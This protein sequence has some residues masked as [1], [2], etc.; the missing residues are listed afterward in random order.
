[1]EKPPNFAQTI[2]KCK[3]ATTPGT[4]SKTHIPQIEQARSR[5]TT[6]SIF[7]CT[8][9]CKDLQ[10]NVQELMQLSEAVL[11]LTYYQ[12]LVILIAYLWCLWRT[13]HGALLDEVWLSWIVEALKHSQSQIVRLLAIAYFYKKHVWAAVSLQERKNYKEFSILFQSRWTIWASTNGIAAPTGPMW[14][15]LRKIIAD[16][17]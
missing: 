13:A 3:H 17:N 4:P 8:P 11:L 5:E 6:V 1:M 9:W 10:V 2:P 14:L 16:R 12:S 15:L 7:H